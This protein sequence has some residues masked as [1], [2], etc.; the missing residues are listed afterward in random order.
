MSVPST[1][2]TTNLLEVMA[3]V[4]QGLYPFA[5]C[6]TCGELMPTSVDHGLGGGVAVICCKCSTP[7]SVT[8]LRFLS[9]DEA[10]VLGWKFDF[11][12]DK[13]VN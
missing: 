6:K 2:M 4:D 11:I 9:A 3:F 12:G 8:L 10:G 7:L 1:A 5:H 13:P